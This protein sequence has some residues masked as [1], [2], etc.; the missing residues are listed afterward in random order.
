M[1]RAEPPEFDRG[2]PGA[3]L[4]MPPPTSRARGPSHLHRL[5][6]ALGDLAFLIFATAA[7]AWAM[8]LG[9]RAAR[10]LLAGALLGMLLAMAVQTLLALAVAPILGSIESM[11]P[12]MVAG[13]AGSMSVCVLHF[14]GGEP[15]PAVAL[16]IGAAVGG[17]A[18]LVFAAY[19]WHCRRALGCCPEGGHAR[20]G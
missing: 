7:A 9:H 19:G 14:A 8:S 18:F 1:N 6:F 10:D 4:A 17:A 5:A 15:S 13:M 2:K 11:V 3:G 16:L 12:S 20:N